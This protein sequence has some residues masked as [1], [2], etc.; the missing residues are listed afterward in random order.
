MYLNVMRR[1]NEV[2]AF[3]DDLSSNGVVKPPNVVAEE[4]RQH[5]TYDVHSKMKLRIMNLVTR[6]VET[7]CQ[8]VS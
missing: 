6:A 7:S 2:A 4:K 1:E 3:Y 8:N 5:I